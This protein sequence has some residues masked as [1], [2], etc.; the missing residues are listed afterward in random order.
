MTILTLNCGSSS[1]KY[2]LF[3]MPGGV[4]ISYG[5][6]DRV[7][8]ERATVEYYGVNNK[9]YSHKCDCTSHDAAV[10]LIMEL[11]VSPKN[12]VIQS[13]AEIKAVGHRVV[14]GGEKFTSTVL[15]DS[16]VIG[17]IEE[18]SA[19]APLH[20]PA[21]LAGIKAVTS[22][23]PDIS[24]VA[25]FDTAFFNTIPPHAYIYGVPYEWYETHWVRKYGF[26]G[27]S[28]SY[29]AGRAV[30]L[31]EKKPE[32]V[33]IITL[34]IGNGVS[35]T[36]VKG[37]KAFDHSMGFTPLEG[38]VMGTRCG[39]TD[40]GIIL[41]MM[42][43]ENLSVKDM[44]EI[45]NKKS[46]LLGI[47]GKYSDR[48]ELLEAMD[49]GDERASLAFE[50]ECYRLRKYIGAYAAGMGGVDAVVFTGGVGENSFRH[51]KKICEGLEFMGIS[52][53]KEKNEQVKGEQTE[54]EISSDQ[55]RVKVF[56][57]PT[58]E[59]MVIAGET[60]NLLNAR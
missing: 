19:L 22:L 44:D 46:G 37:G 10:R 14:H 45:L 60:Y 52:F 41:H 50:I 18:Y 34:H 11:L 48:R 38:A 59:E 54:R 33:N 40:P 2:A 24:Q 12:G 21:N 8:T 15:I 36:A 1:V 5:M 56:V 23:L 55:S 25:V 35:V 53:D 30:A 9:R 20:N 4:R 57:I 58:D 28:H 6:V 26:H 13:M 49:K 27:T 51:R 42:Q 16:G 47:S 31:L 32:E 17:K 43:K 39:D 29:V 3:N 7:G